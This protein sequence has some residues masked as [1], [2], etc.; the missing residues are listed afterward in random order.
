MDK[1]KVMNLIKKEEGTKLDF[2][3]KLDLETESGKK[4]FSKDVSAIANSKGGRGYLIVGVE[5]KSKK[6]VG[7]EI[8]MYSEEQLQQIVSSRC[9]PPIPISVQNILFEDRYVTVIT[10][11][12]GGQKPYQVRENGAFYIR[13]GSTTDTMR[14]QELLTCF[15]ENLIINSELF[16]IIKSKIEFIDN[17]LVDKYFSAINIKVTEENRINLME[18]ASIVSFDREDGEYKI[19][20]GGVLVFCPQNSMYIPHNMIRIIDKINK[21]S[22]DTIIIQGDLL[23]ILD[24]SEEVLYNI[25]P[26]DYPAE[27]VCEAI[28]NGVLYRDYT[29]FYKEI[30]VIIDFNSISV[31]SPGT[32]VKGK[33]INSHNYFRRNMWIYEKLIAL[34]EKKRFVKTGRGFTRMK[35]A[36][37]NYGKVIF[38]NSLNDD[39]FK[40]I[41]PGINHFR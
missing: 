15:Q 8:P 32:L 20:L 41:F 10:I 29:L 36:F 22:N 40:V 11:Y 23:S 34:D 16:P 35:K 2:K 27:A 7:T 26:K 19:T 14:K 18:N 13:R 33:D 3:L 37:K 9:E 5:D 28:K 21:N 6:I 12:D 17:D 25:L 39:C 24:K 30:E 38:I 31:I 4:E 1:K